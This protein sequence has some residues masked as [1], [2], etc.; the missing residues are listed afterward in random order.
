MIYLALAAGLLAFLV[1]VG[2]SRAQTRAG[3]RLAGALIAALAATGAVVAG[4][5]GAWMVSLALV[6]L[7]AFLGQA[8]RRAPRPPPPED[9][10]PDSMSPDQARA[11][12][13]V[14]PGAGRSEIE[15]AYRRLIVR[16]HP[17]R[18]GTSGLA[19]QLNAARDRLVK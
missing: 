13:G 1:W 12:L 14:A 3:V 7:S 11:I 19:A 10:P 15:R 2:R 17:D 4:L 18:G 16:A 6:A 9:R 8:A 5:R